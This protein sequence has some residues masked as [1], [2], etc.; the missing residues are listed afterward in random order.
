VTAKAKSKIPP[1]PFQ[2][3]PDLPPDQNGRY[4]CRAPGCHLVGE[5]DDIHHTMPDVPA[6]AEHHGR[7]EH[8]ED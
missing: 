1:H 5:P 4:V 3:D 6:Q 2:R 7:Y 8:E